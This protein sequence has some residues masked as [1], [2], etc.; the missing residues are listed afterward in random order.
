MGKKR[1]EKGKET[2]KIFASGCGYTVDYAAWRPR[3]RERVRF[4][5]RKNGFSMSVNSVAETAQSR[6][7][8]APRPLENTTKG[9]GGKKKK[10]IN[11]N[12]EK[13]ERNNE[14]DTR[15]WCMK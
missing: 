14:R 15:S 3:P 11:F 2:R 6:L 9:R 12:R 7:T 13:V 5:S 1:G 8:R 10:R 4:F